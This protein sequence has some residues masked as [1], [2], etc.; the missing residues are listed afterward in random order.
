MMLP[1]PFFTLMKVTLRHITL[2]FA[3]A[4]LRHADTVSLFAAV[5]YAMPLHAY[6]ELRHTP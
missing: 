2:I 1:P 4:A 6:A 3:Y 5:Y